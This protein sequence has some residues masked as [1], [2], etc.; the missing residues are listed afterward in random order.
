MG[1]VATW[2]TA[3]KFLTAGANSGQQR[4][5]PA[6]C[7]TTSRNT[8]WPDRVGPKDYWA[9]ASAGTAEL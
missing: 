2:I 6:D 1:T 7:L 4:I 3:L 9:A 5:F 8:P